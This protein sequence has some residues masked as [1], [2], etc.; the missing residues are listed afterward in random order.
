MKRYLIVPFSR[1]RH[2]NPMQRVFNYRQSRA[3]RIIEYAFGLMQEK[4]RVFGKPIGLNV[5]TCEKIVLAVACIHNFLITEELQLEENQRR[6]IPD[7]DDHDNGNHDGAE[8]DDEDD[9]DG[10]GQ[11]NIGP[12]QIA[13]RAIRTTLMNYFVNEG[14]L[15]WQYERV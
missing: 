5:L 1:I 9:N 8:N 11:Q 13:A 12:N 7:N 3:R 4:W 14:E 15:N 2:L 6:Y 10:A